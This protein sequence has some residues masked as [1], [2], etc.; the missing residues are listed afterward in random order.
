MT[1]GVIYQFKVEARNAVGYSPQSASVT[2][3][4][5]AVADAPINLVNEPSVTDATQIK[6]SWTP[7]YD[8]GT[9]ILDYNIY[10][11]QS[12]GSFV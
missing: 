6:F 3:M 2:I 12:Y 9:P 11:D 1:D 7:D 8:G 10:Y 5:A 4:A